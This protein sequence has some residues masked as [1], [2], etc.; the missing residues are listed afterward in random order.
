[1][2]PQLGKQ[3][4]AGPNQLTLGLQARVLKYGD[5]LISSPPLVSA[6]RHEAV[7]RCRWPG[8]WRAGRQCRRLLNS[9]GRGRRLWGQSQRSVVCMTGSKPLLPRI[10]A[11]TALLSSTLSPCKQVQSGGGGQWGRLRGMQM[12]TAVSSP[13]GW[14][15]WV[16]VVI[17]AGRAAVMAVVPEAWVGA[18]T[19]LGTAGAWRGAAP[20]RAQL[21]VAKRQQGTQVA[22]S[23]ALLRR[24]RW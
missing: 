7:R 23:A 14:P 12:L 19:G 3:T 6:E 5:Q 15:L 18:V 21:S 24:T 9:G 1:M 8:R 11:S 22:G 20:V 4:A 17:A 10:A 13:Q 16:G 2:L